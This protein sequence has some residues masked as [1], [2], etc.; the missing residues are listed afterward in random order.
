[1]AQP[2]HRTHR[3]RTIDKADR[4]VSDLETLE[5]RLSAAI[6]DAES[7]RDA[8]ELEAEPDWPDYSPAVYQQLRDTVRRLQQEASDPSVQ[9]DLGRVNLILSSA[10]G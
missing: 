5:S 7:I 6:V 8:V 4:L 10:I 3:A 9:L 2:D 1:M